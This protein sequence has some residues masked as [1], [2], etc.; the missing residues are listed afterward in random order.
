MSLVRRRVIVLVAASRWQP[1]DQVVSLLIQL[2]LLP[3]LL[4]RWFHT[5]PCSR[6]CNDMQ[7]GRLAILPTKTN[8][9]VTITT[10]FLR[11]SFPISFSFSSSRLLFFFSSPVLC[12]YEGTRCFFFYFIFFFWSLCV[13]FLLWERCPMQKQTN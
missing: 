2:L 10:F 9:L 12:R 3:L 6:W 1:V 13:L 11:R 8:V 4:L 5:A 7:S